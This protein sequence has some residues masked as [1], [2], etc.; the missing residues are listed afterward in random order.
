MVNKNA[1]VYFFE[2][3]SDNDCTTEKV[4]ARYEWWCNTQ[5]EVDDRVSK[6]IAVA[7]AEKT[8]TEYAW[9]K[10]YKLMETQNRWPS[11]D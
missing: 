6:F 9:V 5:K 1:G 2:V 3:H 8:A 7:I 10:V 11:R 4:V